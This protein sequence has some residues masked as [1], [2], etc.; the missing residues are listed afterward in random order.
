MG[1]FNHPKKQ[2][3]HDASAVD[4]SELT[5][6]LKLVQSVGTGG[7]D[8][9]TIFEAHYNEIFKD[10]LYPRI[11]ATIRAKKAEPGS[12]EKAWTTLCDEAKTAHAEELFGLVETH[13]RRRLD[14]ARHFGAVIVEHDAKKPT[15]RLEVENWSSIKDRVELWLKLNGAASGAPPPEGPTQKSGKGVR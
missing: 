5:K 13:L 11:A 10:V 9:K 15:W 7:G 2:A 3:N 1:K 14:D 8:Y 6:I 12:D 4:E